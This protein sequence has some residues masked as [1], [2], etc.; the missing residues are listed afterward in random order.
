[1]LNV[2]NYLRLLKL[3][4]MIILH[5]SILFNLIIVFCTINQSIPSIQQVQ[6]ASIKIVDPYIFDYFCIPMTLVVITSSVNPSIKLSSYFIKGIN[7]YGIFAIQ[8]S[9][10]LTAGIALNLRL[11][12][13]KVTLLV[14]VSLPTVIARLAL[15]G[16]EMHVRSVTIDRMPIRRGDIVRDQRWLNGNALI[17]E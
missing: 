7:V 10:L 3:S 12:S 9:L 1:M 5:V 17:I 14:M 15:G 8:T 16:V 11:S 6:N 4:A 13:D 2:P